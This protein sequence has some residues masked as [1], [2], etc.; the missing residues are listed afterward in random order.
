M[1][2]SK[3]NCKKELKKELGSDTV[4]NVNPQLSLKRYLIFKYI[5]QLTWNIDCLILID[6]M[7]NQE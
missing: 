6:R 4:L 2:V 7:G 3:K 1:I 5:Y